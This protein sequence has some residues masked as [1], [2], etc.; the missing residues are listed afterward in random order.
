[1]PWDIG[2]VCRKQVRQEES[3]GRLAGSKDEKL[4][5]TGQGQSALGKGNGICKGMELR[6]GK[7]CLGN[8]NKTKQGLL[9]CRVIKRQKTLAK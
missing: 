4:I 5:D 8:Y 2:D 6:E 3:Q 9:E 1:M 7:I